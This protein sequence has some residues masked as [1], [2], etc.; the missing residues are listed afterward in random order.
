MIDPHQ[1]LPASLP[2]TKQSKRGELEGSSITAATLGASFENSVGLYTSEPERT[3]GVLG[4]PIG[5]AEIPSN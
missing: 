4:K 2:H 5:P 1:I 3:Y